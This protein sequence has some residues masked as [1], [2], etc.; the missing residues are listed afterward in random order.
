[1][2]L[3]YQRWDDILFLHWEVPADALRRRVD[4][5]L[6][7]DAFDGRYF[8]SLTPFTLKKA[9]LRFLPPIPGMSRFHELNFRT[10]VRHGDRSGIW[11]F[12]LD[13]AN[14]VAS[15]LARIT[16]GLP[17]Y[18]SRIR[19]T[20][21]GDERHYQMERGFPARTASC[22]ITWTPGRELGPHPVGSLEHFLTE[23]YS[24]F[25]REPSGALIRV[26]VRHPAWPLR[27]ALGVRLNETLSGAHGL[28]GPSD[29]LIAHASPGVDVAFVNVEQVEAP[30][31]W[32]RRAHPKIRSAHG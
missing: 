29:G 17:Y 4:S 10:Y 12:S 19:R 15:A 25:S 8:V 30:E 31:S 32:G 13:A 18:S 20:Y 11:F 14:P 3:G 16:F 23:R 21:V 5:R 1:M 26:D 6:Q 28:P 24:L 2:E 9:R 27:E 7:L 22:D